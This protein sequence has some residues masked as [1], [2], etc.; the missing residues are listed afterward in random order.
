MNFISRL[1]KATRTIITL[2]K[3]EKNTKKKLAAAT[4]LLWSVC[5]DI[6]L[7]YAYCGEKSRIWSQIC[8]SIRRLIKSAGFDPCMSNKDV[9]R[10][11]TRLDPACMAQ[12]QIIQLGIKFLDESELRDRRFNI[13]F[14][15]NDNN[16]PF[17]AKFKELF[18][19]LPMKSRE[20]IANNLDPSDHKCRDRIKFHLKKH[21]QHVFEPDGPISDKKRDQIIVSNLYS[22]KVAEERRK[23][24]SINRERRQLV[25]TERKK[26]ADEKSF[27][28]PKKRRKKHSQTFQTPKLI[29]EVRKSWAPL[30]LSTKPA[31]SPPEIATFNAVPSRPIPNDLE[32]PRREEVVYDTIRDYIN[33][34]CHEQDKNPSF[35][36]KLNS[37]SSDITPECL[38]TPN[39]SISLDMSF[40]TVIEEP[41]FASGEHDSISDSKEP[42]YIN[43]AK[44][45]RASNDPKPFL[46]KELKDLNLLRPP[47]N[48]DKQSEL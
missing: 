40:E 31:Y 3:F 35:I 39:V 7:I 34:P 30:R 41:P 23:Q 24:N 44:V 9:Y 36:L 12:K 46:L 11:S 22:K 47:E 4:Q 14:C 19:A 26:R 32:V 48:R 10:I 13:K 29:K 20:F 27:S 38:S 16:R 17:W 42:L 25:I 1:S 8:V 21:F 33:N 37:F 5:F 6:G 43:M 2:R 18:H 28:T 45:S 15:T